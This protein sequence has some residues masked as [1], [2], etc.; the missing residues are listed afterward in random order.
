MGVA[1]VNGGE[2]AGDIG[3]KTPLFAKKRIASNVVKQ[4]QIASSG[5][6]FPPKRASAEIEIQ[7][8]PN[9][10]AAYLSARRVP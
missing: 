6:V 2:D 8:V 7:A 9:Q 3:H 4:P 1:L 5:W 10:L